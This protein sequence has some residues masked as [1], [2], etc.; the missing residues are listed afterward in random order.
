[1]ARAFVSDAKYVILDEPTA[2]L[3]P[4][5]ESRMYENFSRIFHNRGTILISHRLA[6]ARMADRILVLDGGRIVQAGNHVELM[7]KQGLYRT[8]FLA[9]SS[10]YGT[11]TEAIRDGSSGDNG[12][13]FYGTEAE[14]GE[15]SRMA[16]GLL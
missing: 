1:M 15:C 9:Q 13:I 8:M 7:G 3:D 6:S 2:S 10:F 14:G 16:G 11:G 12:S 5:A 4:V